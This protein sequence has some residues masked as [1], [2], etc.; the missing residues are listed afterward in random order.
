MAETLFQFTL[1]V[2]YFSWF[3]YVYFSPFLEVLVSSMLQL[4][5][6]ESSRPGPQLWFFSGALQ[7][8][9]GWPG[10]QYR[11]SGSPKSARAAHGGEKSKGE[12]MPSDIV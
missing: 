10:G 11:R 8:Q 6:V 4:A 1:I 9:G 7:C 5:F 2:Q 12:R 3:I